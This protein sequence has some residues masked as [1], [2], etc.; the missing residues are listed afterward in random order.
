MARAGAGFVAIFT[1]SPKAIHAAR[2]TVEHQ[3]SGKQL[4]HLRYHVSDGR[5]GS[6]RTALGKINAV[7]GSLRE[8]FCVI[9]IN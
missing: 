2:R 8:W 1:V 9:A 6:N 4:Q 5:Q 3:E 7:T